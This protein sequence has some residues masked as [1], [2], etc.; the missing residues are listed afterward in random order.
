M[1]QGRLATANPTADSVVDLY[2]PSA[3]K[4]ATVSVSICNKGADT[5]TIRLALTSAGSASL[6]AGDYLEY[7]KALPANESMQI[8]G[9][10]L[11]APETLVCRASSGN[12]DFV[13]FGFEE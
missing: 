6:A 5:A 4:V 10:V 12:V 3:G 7:D 8:T 2:T 11:S 1:A 9:I 13:A